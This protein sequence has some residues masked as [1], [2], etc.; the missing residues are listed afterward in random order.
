MK[1]ITKGISVIFH[2]VFIPMMAFFLYLQIDHYSV[3]ILHSLT[4][5][6]FWLLF[7]TIGLFTFLLP[8]IAINAM[9]STNIVE[10]WELKNH[11]ERVPVLIFTA[12][13][14]ACLYYVF[15]F[16]EQTN[17]PIFKGFF[18]VIMSGIALAIIAAIISHFWKISMHAIGISG[19]AGAM[20]GLTTIL[21]PVLNVEEMVLI[22]S[23]VIGVAG[24]VGFSR[25][26]EKA[27]N[28]AQVIAGMLLGFGVSFFVVIKEW[29]F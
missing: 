9:I 23:I 5:N 19:L 26:Y 25:L 22:N 6:G 29:Y 11:K 10:S 21:H 27:H 2:P 13:F 28:L 24:L 14:L 7:A 15:T 1:Y 12:I 18:A 17:G 20:V 3:A 16:F 8:M 4:D